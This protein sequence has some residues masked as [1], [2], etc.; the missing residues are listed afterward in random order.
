MSELIQ[1]SLVDFYV[2]F[3]PMECRHIELCA[4]DDLKIRNKKDD[5]TII[6]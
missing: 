4:K 5:V 6:R 3:L 2:P 1:H